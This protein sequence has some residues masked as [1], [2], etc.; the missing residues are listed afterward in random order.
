MALIKALKRAATMKPPDPRDSKWIT[1]LKA[2]TNV[3]STE[4]TLTTQ[5]KLPLQ[6]NVFKSRIINSIRKVPKECQNDENSFLDQ[7][8]SLTTI[9][10]KSLKSKSMKSLI[11]RKK[12]P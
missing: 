2:R 7:C 1:E 5:H 4:R 10:L 8:Q 11:R 3:Q 9:F 12:A 6:F